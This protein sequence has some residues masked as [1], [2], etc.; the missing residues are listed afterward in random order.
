MRVS[1][2]CLSIPL[3]VLLALS[4][5]STF[6]SRPTEAPIVR[7]GPTEIP[8]NIL[9]KGY[10]PPTTLADFLVHANPQVDRRFAVQLAQLYV[11]EG[12]I[13]GV[14]SDVA[15]SQMCLETGF[16]RF[17]NLVTEAMHNYCGLGSLG[18][19]HPGLSFPTPQIGVRA[20]IQHLKGYATDEALHQTLVDPRYRYIRYGSAP[21]IYALAGRWASDKEYGNKIV[22]ILKRLYQFSTIVAQQ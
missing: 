5:C 22:G 2:I 15:F 20:H 11:D 14:N 13:E 9:G 18:P 10:V 17:G 1:T 4:S 3:G 6:P 7:P 16:F 19:G 8:E 21:T 12:A